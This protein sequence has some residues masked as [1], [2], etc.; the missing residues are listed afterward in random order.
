MFMNLQAQFETS[1]HLIPTGVKPR[2]SRKQLAYPRWMQTLWKWSERSRQR[3]DLAALDDRLLK[4]VG[5]SPHD[6][7]R[8]IANPFWR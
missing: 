4:D 3:R 7:A 1:D 5:I 2:L 8:E 6:A